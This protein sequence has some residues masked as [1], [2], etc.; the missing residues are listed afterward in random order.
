MDETKDRNQIEA[1]KR[2]IEAIRHEKPK[3]AE[4]LCRRLLDLADD[5]NDAL[6][7]CFAEYHL[8]ILYAA[9]EDPLTVLDHIGRT[10]QLCLQ[11]PG[12]DDLLIRLNNLEGIAYIRRGEYQQAM[13][14]FLSG[15]RQAE[16]ID[17][18]DVL[19]RMWISIAGIFMSLSQHAL[20]RAYL[21]KAHQ[22]LIRLPEGPHRSFSQAVYDIDQATV[23]L[24][25]G[26][27]DQALSL[28]DERFPD[29]GG[30]MSD[31]MI[32][33]QCLRADAW[34]TLGDQPRAT[35]ILD[36]LVPLRVSETLSL[37]TLM[38]AWRIALNYAIEQ[39]DEN[40]A[41]A[42]F[43][44][45]D[46][47]Y[48]DSASFENKLSLAGARV[49]YH[50]RFGDQRQLM[51]A[52]SDF[53][54][55][56]TQFKEREQKQTAEALD[57]QM[58]LSQ[59][60]AEIAQA[61]RDGLR[62]HSL[63]VKDELTGLA[64][65]RGWRERLHQMIEEQKKRRGTVGVALLDLDHFKRYNDQYGHLFGDKVLC[66][67]AKSLRLDPERFFPGRYGGDEFILVFQGMTD[68]DVESMLDRVF[69]YLERAQTAE[70]YAQLPRITFSAGYVVANAEQVEQESD[71]IEQADQALYLCKKSN[72]HCYRGAVFA[73][74]KAD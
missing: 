23:L 29:G 28:L 69:D 70:E 47:A 26:A 58:R 39:G 15:V 14:C 18:A 40:R 50:R 33:V 49:S 4:R 19:M 30:D 24:N 59:M 34:K 71:L 9:E 60:Q 57:V 65:R 1:I 10:R 62:M 44:A 31:L 5:A 74:G 68:K 52:Y 11:T 7:Y 32:S 43:A 54:D 2:Q 6:A 67:A 72:R 51:A 8:T 41:K 3:Q 56:T 63:S 66:M 55:L 20:A 42:A 46:K 35:A 45:I 21:D 73:P 12:T 38:E 36:K 48:A 27:P 25:T 61:Q 16:P 37:G 22:Y 13:R 64:N 17:D 53:Y